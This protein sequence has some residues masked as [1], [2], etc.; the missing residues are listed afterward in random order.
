MTG[1]PTINESD[2]PNQIPTSALGERKAAPL[3]ESCP[4]QV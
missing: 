4:G 1:S 3:C 2:G